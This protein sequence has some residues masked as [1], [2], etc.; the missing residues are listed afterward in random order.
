MNFLKSFSNSEPTEKQKIEAVEQK[1][2]EELLEQARDE[3]AKNE[4]EE[5]VKIIRVRKIESLI[6]LRLLGI[7]GRDRKKERGK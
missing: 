5:K 3:R 4:R 6:N 7:P 2:F 1:R